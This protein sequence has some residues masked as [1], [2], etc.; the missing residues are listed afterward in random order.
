[1][2]ILNLFLGDQYN[3]QF[4]CNTDF[5]ITRFLPVCVKACVMAETKNNMQDVIKISV[6]LSVSVCLF[7]TFVIGFLGKKCAVRRRVKSVS[8]VVD[9]VVDTAVRSNMRESVKDLEG[10]VRAACV[11]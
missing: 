4:C 8:D 6:T 5:K 2:A 3:F 10:K 11:G 1:M 9:M 7:M